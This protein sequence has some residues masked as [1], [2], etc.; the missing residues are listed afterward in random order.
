[1][2]LINS[3]ETPKSQILIWPLEL[4]RMLDGLI[5]DRCERVRDLPLHRF[6]THG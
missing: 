6:E 2:E 3:P 5:S 1:M 4:N